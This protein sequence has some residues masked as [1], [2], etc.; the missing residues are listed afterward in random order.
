M[1]TTPGLPQQNRRLA[2]VMF[3]DMCGYSA[4]MAKDEAL[5]LA[6]VGALEKLLRAEIP[7]HGGRLVKFLGDGSMAEFPTALASVTCSQSLLTMIEANNAWVAPEKRYAVR[8]GLNLG[9]LVD[10]QDDIFSDTVNVA[11]RVQPLANPGG[12]AMTSLIYSQVKN[13][14]SLK[15]TYLPPQK[16]KNIPEKIRIFLVHPNQGETPVQNTGQH[17]K[18]AIR[19]AVGVVL[20]LAAAWLTHLLLRR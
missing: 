7:R 19:V 1:D 4:M 11:A 10:V 8:I 16:L 2:A 5:A 20:L 18:L 17:R 3:L 15:G 14:L 9:E 13:Q 6:C 12:I